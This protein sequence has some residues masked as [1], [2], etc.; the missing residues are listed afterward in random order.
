M[1]Y[2]PP[3]YWMPEYGL[4]RQQIAQVRELQRRPAHARRR[5]LL[6]FKE[7]HHARGRLLYKY[8]GFD[9]EAHADPLDHKKAADLIVDGSLYLCAPWGFN[10]P[11]EF[12]AQVSVTTDAVE[13]RKWVVRMATKQAVHEGLKGSARHRRINELTAKM[14]GN[15][16]ESPDLAQASFDESVST[17]GV[18]C[19]AEDPRNTLMW[20][21]YARGHKGI[22]VQLDPSFCIGVLGQAWPVRYSST[23][24]TFVWPGANEVFNALLTK[25]EDW[26]YE[27][28]HR[29]LSM[30]V[31]NATIAFDARAVTGII[32][33]RR[34]ERAG[35][36]GQ[37]LRGLLAARSALGLPAVKLYH[38]A[39]A[40]N[41]YNARIFSTTL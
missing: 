15:M 35:A 5:D 26:R 33:G 34:F 39:P 32:L 7:E 17:W 36:Q 3:D 11:D 40:A 10:D 12:R 31:Q 41:S 8:L 19:F 16:I 14:I 6:T 4:T 1:T 29:V 21:H 9:V 27:R 23:L 2:R 38:E 30:T 18:A 13:R 24:P 37:A 22:A 28:E 25:S 20:S